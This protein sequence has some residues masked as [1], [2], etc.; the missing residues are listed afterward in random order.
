[1]IRVLYRQVEQFTR[2][3]DAR[4]IHN[5]NFYLFERRGNL[6][7]DTF[8]AC[9]VAHNLLAGFDSIQTTDVQTHRGVKF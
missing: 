1:M 6:I 5:I 7:F 3:G 2:V 8:H 9:T 4:P